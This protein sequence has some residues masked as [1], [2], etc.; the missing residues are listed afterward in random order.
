MAETPLYRQLGAKPE[1][2]AP[3][4]G[5]PY[6]CFASTSDVLLKTALVITLL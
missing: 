1:S 3:E 6:S 4:G 5:R 2:P